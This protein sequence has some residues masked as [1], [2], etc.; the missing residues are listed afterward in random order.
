VQLDGNTAYW[1]GAW[2]NMLVL[3]ACA[4]SG[5]RLAERQEIERHSKRMW[6]AVGLVVLFV[7]SYAGKLALLGREDLAVWERSFVHVLRVHELCVLV[8]VPAGATSLR[9]ALRLELERPLREPRTG[10]DAP[11][12]ARS[13]HLHRRAGWVAIGAGAL[14]VL[15]AGYVLLG[16]WQ[17]LGTI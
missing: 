17:R 14:G 7:A 3:V 15:T 10:I 12:L 8:M 5:A 4:I 6:I 16:F 9:I 1:T 13:V 11:A 2:I